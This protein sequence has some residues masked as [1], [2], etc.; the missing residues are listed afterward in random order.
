[1]Y[2]VH[3]NAPYSALTSGRS[4]F[5]CWSRKYS[6]FQ[7]ADEVDESGRDSQQRRQTVEESTSEEAGSSMGENTQ[8]VCSAQACKNWPSSVLILILGRRQSQAS[9]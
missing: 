1:M 3:Y 7:R 9:E 6:P 2:Q 5:L 4:T 8:W